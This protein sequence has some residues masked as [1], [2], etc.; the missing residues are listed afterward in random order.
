[1]A[2]LMSSVEVK[3]PSRAAV[4]ASHL[5]K[6]GFEKTRFFRKNRIFP[7]PPSNFCSRFD[8]MYIRISVM[9]AISSVTTKLIDSLSKK[10]KLVAK[11]IN[12]QESEADLSAQ[13]I[14]QE[15]ITNTLPKSI[16]ARSIVDLC[17][18]AFREIFENIIVYLGPKFVG[19]KVFK[20][21]YS[22]KLSKGLQD[23]VFTEAKDLLKEEK[24][25]KKTLMPI[26]AAIA[27]S[28]LSI[29][30][31]EYALSYV[32]NLF[33]LKMF[34]Q[35]DF[36]NIANLNKDKVETNEHQEKVKESAKKHIKLTGGL[37][38]GCL[39]F[40]ALL[41]TKGKDSKVLNHIS[42]AVLAPGS[43]F[44]KNNE[45][46][47][48]FFNK[49]FG[50]DFATKEIKDKEGKVISRKFAISK[51][52]IVASVIAGFFG[53]TG[54]AKD[55][56]KQDY[57]EVLYRFPL[58]GL[59][60][61][62][63]NELFVKGFNNYMK[64]SGKCKE[65]FDC[66]AKNKDKMPKLMELGNFAHELAAKNGTTAKAEFE[67]LLKQKKILIGVPVLFGFTVM[68]LFVAACSRY[69][70]QYRYNKDKQAQ[71]MTKQ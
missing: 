26:K 36:N 55:R 15:L 60:A 35:A 19:E 10:D 49:Y 30:L 65:L 22:K 67:K 32:K 4:T 24:A 46:Y 53:Y 39:A 47:K 61:I 52:Q 1:M 68:G 3:T 16:F 57:K 51:G 33:T 13:R 59:Y 64:K 21:A 25:D 58:V 40:S 8:F 42:E 20:K 11:F 50:L 62:V 23:T 28:A 18:N 5:S 63:G 7:N 34:K 6:V 12:L 70:T 17:D 56:G 9:V 48:N 2:I 44:F 29:P 41:V 43:K 66:Q 14:G 37:I 45:K 71:E 38:A 31:A 54:A 69:F 27:V